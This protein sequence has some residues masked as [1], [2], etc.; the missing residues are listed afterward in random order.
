MPLTHLLYW[1]ELCLKLI[2]R[3][4]LVIVFAECRFHQYLSVTLVTD[5]RPLC[6][7]SGGVPPLA[8]AHMQRWTLLLSAY[9][10]NIK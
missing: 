6:K 3:E 7:I 5:H 8:A 10:Y 1:R 2:E 4:A 9:S